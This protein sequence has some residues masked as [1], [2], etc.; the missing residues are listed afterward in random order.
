MEDENTQP[1]ETMV[2]ITETGS[3]YHIKIDCSHIKLSVREVFGLPYDLR[4]EYGAKY[5]SCE[6]CCTGREVED[7]IYYIT[8]DGTKYHTRRTCSKIKRN[9][10]EIR[11]SEVGNRAPCKRCGN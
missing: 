8:S 10:R 4:N 3:V 5:D 9:V 2:Y 1:E 11:L 6:A 7:A